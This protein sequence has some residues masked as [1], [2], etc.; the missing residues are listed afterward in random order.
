MLQTACLLAGVVEF[1]LQ[2][3]RLGVDL[4]RL[5]PYARFS[6]GELVTLLLKSG[7]SGGQA[8]FDSLPVLA[9]ER[10][11]GLE[12]LNLAQKFDLRVTRWV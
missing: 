5:A 9:G 4:A 12:C 7:D 6:F 10:I 2:F 3:A 11:L 1:F 8:S